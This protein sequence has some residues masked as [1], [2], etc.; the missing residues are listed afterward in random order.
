MNSRI[1]SVEHYQQALK[2]GRK[3]QKQ[4]VHQGLYPYLQ[5]LDEILPEYTT[6]G[7]EELGT[8]E[9]PVEKIVGTKTRGRSDAFA[10]NFMPLIPADSEFG[11]KW[12]S[13]C[14]YH[15][16]DSGIRDPISC[17]E[18][19]G[20]F[21]VQEGNKRVSVLKYFDAATI[22]GNVIRILPGESSLPEVVAYKEFLTY[23]PKTRL[24]EVAFSRLNS[25]PKLQAALGYEP[26]H[27]WTEE[28]RRNFRSS[29]YYFDH[30]F[31]KL[32]DE[33]MTATAAD[34]LLE[35]LKLY[36]FE[37]IKAMSNAELLRSLESIWSTVKAIGQQNII[38]L[39]TKSAVT[40]DKAFKNR[41]A[42][43]MMPSYLNIAF[44][45][46]LLPENSNWVTAHDAGSAYLEKSMGDQVIVQRFAGVGTGEEAERAMEIAIKNG[47]EVIFTT[48]A[49]MITACRRVAARHP[50]T[51]I[52]NCSV[53]MPYT[54][55]RTYY[56][57]IYEGKFISGAIA[58]A[59]SKSDTIGYIASYPIF[60]VPAGINAFALGA[61]LTNPKARVQL[62]WSY[63]SGDPLR[64]L[65]DQGIDVVSTLDIPQQGWS[66]GQWGMF[67][68]Q[69][70]GSSEWIASPYWDWGA[71]YVQIARSIL[72]GEW[73]SSIFSRKSERAV[74]YWWGITNGVIGLEWT[75]KMP[76][77]TKALA[78]LLMEGI[79][80]GT[81]DPFFRKI[82][83][84]D[85]TVRNDGTNVFSPEEILHMDWLCDNVIG[86]IPDFDALSPKAQ[87]ITR[88]QGIY[89]DHIPPQKASAV[90]NQ[91]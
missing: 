90:L 27:T 24:Y 86:S 12:R 64:E 13:L 47:A 58:G 67:Q 42:F 33:P 55:V 50:E 18:F 17:Y 21:Y 46:E 84:Q 36:P 6:A 25:F 65:A 7:R 14:E 44:I 75:D 30:A 77:G 51:K 89:R 9:I 81:V 1:E 23:Y 22:L 43:S 80:H 48:T 5:V 71:F 31:Q 82:V 66:E 87:E 49:S 57:R 41:R 15:L 19:L 8:I 35:W 40:E 39:N 4:R 34:A 79:R 29:F 62:K 78:N 11:L 70:D 76:E 68:I 54:D 88:L 60:G 59:V 53:C 61:Q 3:M 56:S 2:A 52:L 83:T 69:N 85:G 63:V 74:N 91:K 38:E 73:E 37:K 26:D 32:C 10:A 16:G 28:E 45:H 20:N 72:S